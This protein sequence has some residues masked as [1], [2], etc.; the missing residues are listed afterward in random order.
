MLFLIISSSVLVVFIENIIV[1]FVC[2]STIFALSWWIIKVQVINDAIR[3]VQVLKTSSEKLRESSL[4]KDKFLDLMTHDL[5]SSFNSIDGFTTLLL[6]KSQQ[7]TE[8]EKTEYLQYILQSTNNANKLIERLSAWARLH[9]GRWNPNPQ[10]FDIGSLIA[11]VVS[12]HQP[13]AVQRKI[14]LLVD[15]KESFSVFAD[16]LMLETALRN[17]VSNAIKFTQSGGFVKIGFRKQEGYVVIIVRDNGKGMSLELINNLFTL[18]GNVITPDVSGKRGTGLGLILC[19]DLVE[20]NGG[21]IWVKSEENK[22]S[23]IYFTIP[24][25]S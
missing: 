22:G 9:T 5:K 12:F 2:I 18:G 10:S 20:K 1:L 7:H 14:H 8:E 16:E 15:I 23:N 6:D 17:L 24:L 13:Y 4:V 25:S 21:K 19:K 3:T 11:N